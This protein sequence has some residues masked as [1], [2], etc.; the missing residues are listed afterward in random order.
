MPASTDASLFWGLTWANII[1]FLGIVGN[2]VFTSYKDRKARSKAASLDT[3]NHSV[4]TPIEALLQELSGLMDDADDVLRLKKTWLE[5]IQAAKDIK[6]KFHAVRRKL[7]RKLTDCDRSTRVTGTGWS[8]IEGGDMDKATEALD[9]AP[10]A[11]S[12]AALRDSLH[13]FAVAINSFRDRLQ[14]E[15][16]RY[17]AS[18]V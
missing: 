12:T 6:P 3:Y 2:F 15:L 18:C 5:Q 1:A 7:A 14:A 8:A 10:N 9:S 16:D 4:R 13:V 11:E 17:A